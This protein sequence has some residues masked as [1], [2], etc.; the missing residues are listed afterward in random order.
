M[1]FPVSSFRL[2]LSADWPPPRRLSC[3]SSVFASSANI[4]R[5]GAVVG[6]LLIGSVVRDSQLEIVEMP[7]HFIALLI[8]LVRLVL[9]VFR[10]DISLARGYSPYQS[11]PKI[12]VRSSRLCNWLQHQ[13]L[14]CPLTSYSDG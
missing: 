10:A 9:V 14:S 13:G 1:L 4:H 12:S 5:F 7:W 3:V 2:V 11:V 6:L 8:A